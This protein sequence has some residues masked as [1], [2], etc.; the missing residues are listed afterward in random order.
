M[1]TVNGGNYTVNV[2][3]CEKK[4]LITDEVSSRGEGNELVALSPNL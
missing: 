2:K 3:S 1:V 4:K